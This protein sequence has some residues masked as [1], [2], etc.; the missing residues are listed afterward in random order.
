[1]T[2]AADRRIPLIAHRRPG[3]AVLAAGLAV[4]CCLAGGPAPAQQVADPAPDLL[5]VQGRWART[6]GAYAIELSHA[7]G[8]SLEAA[9]F[10][11]RPIHVDRTENQMRDG[12][13]HVLVV[14]QDINYQGSYY[15]LAYH[16]PEE[17]LAGIYFH[18]GSGQQIA[19]EFGRAVPAGP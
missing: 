7:G 18:A 4:L 19:V 3:P 15:L 8:D 5:A 11:P 14:L 17:I 6:D 1:M 2:T 9:Y 13:L 10:N 12:L 16:R